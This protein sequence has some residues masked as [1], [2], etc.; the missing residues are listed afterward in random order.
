MAYSFVAGRTLRR[1]RKWQF[2]SSP[3]HVEKLS[4][5]IVKNKMIFL[6][7][8]NLAVEVA[9]QVI[10]IVV[11]LYPVIKFILCICNF[12]QSLESVIRAVFFFMIWEAFEFV[13][14]SS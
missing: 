4:I 1:H 9:S 11:E 12:H 13:L 10:M 6:R 8:A 2:L 3:L 14:G 5:V 7:S